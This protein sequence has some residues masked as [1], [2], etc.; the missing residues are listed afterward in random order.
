[1]LMTEE[2]VGIDMSKKDKRFDD[3]CHICGMPITKAQIAI[4]TDTY[5]VNFVEKREGDISLTV[6][7]ECYE[8]IKVHYTGGMKR[9]MKRH[10]E[11]MKQ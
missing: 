7:I 6:C 9:A 5:A 8:K 2:W 3:I 4:C 11:A 1:M 10:K